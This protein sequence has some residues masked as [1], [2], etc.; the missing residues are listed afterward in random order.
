[1]P[2]VTLDRIA[3]HA[4][5]NR[6]TVSL[7]L[8][9]HPRI[10]AETRDR[11]RKLA[12]EMG[13]H[14][15]PL[16]TALTEVRR[17]SGC[18]QHAVIAYVTNYST[19][20]GWRP[21]YHKRPDYFPGAS[22]RSSELGYRL[23]HFWLGE[24]G[25]TPRSFWRILWTRGVRGI[26]VGRL[27]PGESSLPLLWDHFPVVAL[28]MTLREPTLHRVSEDFYEGAS[29]AMREMQDLGYKRIGFVF[30][31]E[32]DSPPVG[33]R[34]LGAYLYHQRFLLSPE[35]IPPLPHVEGQDHFAEFR[36]W[37][38]EHKPDAILATHGYTVVEWLNRMGYDVPGAIGV[39]SLVE[40]LAFRKMAG[41]YCD[42]SK[43]GAV[44]AEMLVGLIYRREMGIPA[45]AHE[46]MLGGDWRK[47]E[48]VREQCVGSGQA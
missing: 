14:T 20:Y 17:L 30:S 35:D 22:E 5:V 21:P 15:D 29:K 42:A 33:N 8:R 32:D 9:N 23:E 27:P 41:I 10:S 43:L 25:M 40:D 28:G 26:I 7:A 13:Y 31:E 1:M 19:R 38:T 11:I 48:T 39:A 46:V 47:G 36:H 3:Y 44:A 34:W 2:I 12:T 37:F 6:S 16:V 4:K 45:N 24:P 18:P